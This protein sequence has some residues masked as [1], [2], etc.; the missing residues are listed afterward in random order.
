[1]IGYMSV[2]L[3]VFACVSQSNLILK[4]KIELNSQ[5]Q[6]RILKFR[7]EFNSQIQDRIWS[8]NLESNSVPYSRSVEFW[9]PH[10]HPTHT[11]THIYIL[12]TVVEQLIL[13]L[14]SLPGVYL[15]HSAT[16]CNIPQLTATPRNTP[17]HTATRTYFCFCLSSK[18]VAYPNHISSVCTHASCDMWL[19]I[20]YATHQITYPNHISS[21]SHII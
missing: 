15:Q 10:P 17:Q 9:P 4:L 16:H 6:N 2:C 1:M 7:I 21:K 18:C 11:S 20:T 12:Q 14:G 19:Q 3:C 13:P 8:S 5:I